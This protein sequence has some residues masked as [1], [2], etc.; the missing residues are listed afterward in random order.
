MDFSQ[1]KAQF[2]MMKTVMP[3][4]DCPLK[5]E[6]PE[7]EMGVTSIAMEISTIK[8]SCL[9]EMGVSLNMIQQHADE[10][11]RT[12]LEPSFK[13]LAQMNLHIECEMIPP[14]VLLD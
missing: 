6:R 13:T 9:R 5:C 14:P 3:A 10:S 8:T 1:L 7:E 4:P 11:W 2:P 12:K